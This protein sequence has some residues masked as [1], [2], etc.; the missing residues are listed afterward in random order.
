MNKEQ[1]KSNFNYIGR[2]LDDYLQALYRCGNEEEQN[3]VI[4]AVNLLDKYEKILLG[5]KYE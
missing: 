4:C 1:V 3:E 5:G 2:V